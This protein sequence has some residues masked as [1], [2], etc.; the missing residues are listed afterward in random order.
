MFYLKLNN[1]KH[2]SAAEKIS[3]QKRAVSFI[4]EYVCLYALLKTLAM[5]NYTAY[6]NL[7]K[8]HCENYVFKRQEHAF[9][10]TENQSLMHA[11]NSE[12]SEMIS[13]S[14]ALKAK[15]ATLLQKAKYNPTINVEDLKKEYAQLINEHLLKYFHNN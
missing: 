14:Q 10:S 11:L 6:L 7:M 2:Y 8:K 13:A 9:L 15:A 3:E 12:E 5:T 1:N 4:D